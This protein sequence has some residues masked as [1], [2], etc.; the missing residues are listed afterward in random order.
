METQVFSL[1][2]GYYFNQDKFC[3]QL[4]CAFSS[5][6]QKNM[7][8]FYANIEDSLEH[9]RK[10]LSELGIDYGSLVCAQ[11]I[12]GS[13]VAYVQE[14]DLGRGALTYASALEGTD[15]LITDKKNIPLAI[16]TADCPSVFIYDPLTPAIGLLHAG[17]RSTRYE[18]IKNTIALMQEKF[19]SKAKQLCVMFAPAIR[20]CCYEVGKEFNDF[21]SFGLEH[22]NGRFYLD[23]VSLNHKQAQE[24]GVLEENIFDCAMCTS[25]RNDEFFSYRKE[26]KDCGRMMSVMML[27]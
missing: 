1:H 12:H 4:L 25:C 24:S 15:A 26:T 23:L 2:K 6:K 21:F 11:Q 18:I 22:K 13:N 16:F 20:N 5:R 14:K 19:N 10:F 9:R 17:W 7:S 8:L 3:G 27:K